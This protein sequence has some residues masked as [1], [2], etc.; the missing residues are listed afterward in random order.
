MT[1]IC[2]KKRKIENKDERL[3]MLFECKNKNLNFNRNNFYEKNKMNKLN[4]IESDFIIKKFIKKNMI[5]FLLGA[6]K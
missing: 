2:Y 1:S 3:I 6:F 5:N 4:N